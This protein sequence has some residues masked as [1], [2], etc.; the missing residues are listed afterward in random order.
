MFL[1]FL[2]LFAVLGQN[3]VE[4]HHQKI[5]ECFSGADVLELQQHFEGN[6]GR[7]QGL[8]G[9]IDYVNGFSFNSLDQQ[10]RGN[11]VT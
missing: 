4:L 5:I 3:V 8:E 11:T 10:Q 2:H 7:A 9:L 1:M 6:R